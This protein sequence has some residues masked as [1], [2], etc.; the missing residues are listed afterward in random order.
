MKQIFTLLVSM[1]C[2]SAVAQTPAAGPLD[3]NFNPTFSPAFSPLPSIITFPSYNSHPYHW[4][5]KP[6]AS[7]S[8]GYLFY[9]GGSASYL[10]APVGLALIRPLN[11]NWT[12]FG[13]ATISPIAI[14]DTH[15]WT[16]PINDPNFHGSPFSSGYNLGINT[17]IQGGLM[18]TNQDKTFSISGSVHLERSSYPVYPT[19]QSTRPGKQ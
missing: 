19:Y 7:V 8:A 18:Y 4:Q 15:L 1:A 6:F 10:S 2:L 11:P 17:G 12:V 14:Q 16:S 9:N 3:Y 13:A 5:L